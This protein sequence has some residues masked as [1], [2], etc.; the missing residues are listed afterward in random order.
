VGQELGLNSIEKNIDEFQLIYRKLLVLK[1][2]AACLEV[3]VFDHFFEELFQ[4]FVEVIL[5]L[6][7]ESERFFLLFLEN[8]LNLL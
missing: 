7:E 5:L 4:D 1:I 6:F 8:D 3:L 2:Y